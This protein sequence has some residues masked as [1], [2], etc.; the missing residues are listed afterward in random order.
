MFDK[1]CH[2]TNTMASTEPF[3]H[4][5]KW[6]STWFYLSRGP[7]A[8]VKISHFTYDFNSISMKEHWE[9]DIMIAFYALM[10][11]KPCL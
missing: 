7:L 4:L 11:L 9:M 1:L 2:Y 3:Q 10:T 5:H 8:D 6:N